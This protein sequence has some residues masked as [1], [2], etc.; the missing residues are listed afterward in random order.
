MKSELKGEKRFGLMDAERLNSLLKAFDS[1]DFD[2]RLLLSNPGGR[3]VTD[4]SYERI[5]I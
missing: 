1:P 4:E 2:D 3:L 5:S